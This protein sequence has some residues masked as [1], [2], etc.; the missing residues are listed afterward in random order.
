[1]KNLSEHEHQKLFVQWCRLKKYPIFAI[2]NGVNKPNWA[3][4]QYYK[5]EGL[6]AG[7]PDLCLP[8]ARKG[9]HGLFIEMKA[10][11]G[12]LT[13]PQEVKIAQLRDDGYCVKVCFG[14]EQAIKTVEEYIGG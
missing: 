11:R 3:T 12:R 14:Y 9:H 5:D 10:P 1:M 13:K 4:R 8:K 6:E 7:V 2:T